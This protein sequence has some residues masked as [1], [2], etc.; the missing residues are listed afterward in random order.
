LNFA[1]R[2]TRKLNRRA[3]YIQVA[4]GNSARLAQGLL[5]SAMLQK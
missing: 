3:P 5:R 2:L 1:V 4:E